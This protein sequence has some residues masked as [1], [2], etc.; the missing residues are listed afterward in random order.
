MSNPIDKPGGLQQEPADD[1]RSLP[2]RRTLLE[3]R[4]IFK[5][6]SSVLNCVVRNISESGARLEVEPSI[7]VPDRF[8]LDVASAGIR[9]SCRLVWRR[10]NLVGVSAK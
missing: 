2:R 8:D 9:M 10:G 5:Q 4:I 1:R 6:Q 7:H 3:G